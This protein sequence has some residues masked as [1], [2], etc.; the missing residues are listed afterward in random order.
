MSTRRWSSHDVGRRSRGRPATSRTRRWWSR[1][2]R[3]PPTPAPRPRTP[4]GPGAQAALRTW[5]SA[6]NVHRAGEQRRSRRPSSRRAGRPARI[7]GSASRC[8]SRAAPTRSIRTAR[9]S[10]ARR[11]AALPCSTCEAVRAGRRPIWRTRALTASIFTDSFTYPSVNVIAKVPGRDPKLRD[12]YVLFSAHQD[13]DGERYTVNG[14]NI[15]NGA[16]DNATTS[17]ALLAIGRAMAASP[18]RRSALFIWHGSEERGLMGSRWYVKHPTVPLKSIVACLNGDM[19]G[20]ND[21]KTAALLGALPPHRNSPELVDMAHAANKAVSQF[22]VDSSWD[23]PNHREGWYYRSDHLPYA[24]AGDSRA[25]LH[26]AAAPGLP[27]AVRQSGSDRRRE[28]HEDDAVDVRD[29]PR[30]W[31]K[32]TRRRRWIR[33]SS[34]IGAATLREITA[35][36][37]A[38]LADVSRDASVRS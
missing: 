15:W 28:A 16:D 2:R 19:M 27:H 4:V 30:R 13:H 36:R 9:P 8:R 18:G 26:H 38:A 31:P 11:R 7:S 20:R 29:R 33:R 35:D 37:S 12:E 3:R 23:D 1:L 6:S 25:V 32:P 10:S 21:P 34:S 17:V 5:C 22:V 24:R 14:D